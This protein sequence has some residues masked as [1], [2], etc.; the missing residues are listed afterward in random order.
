MINNTDMINVVMYTLKS[1]NV[2]D[3]VSFKTFKKDRKVEIV[4]L[5][6]TY[7][8]IED[9]FEKKKFLEIEYKEVKKILKELQKKEFPRSNKIL[10]KIIRSNKGI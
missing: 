1:I 10:Y 9:G 5:S 7:N 8:I 6:K 3:K 2:N 4:K